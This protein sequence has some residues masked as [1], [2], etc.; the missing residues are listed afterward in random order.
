[1]RT[2]LNYFDNES[3]FGWNASW[4]VSLAFQIVVALITLM[5]VGP[6]LQVTPGTN[7]NSKFSGVVDSHNRNLR[8]LMFQSKGGFQP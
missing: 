1:M 7:Y 3:M 2:P 4:C 6:M 8:A 5:K